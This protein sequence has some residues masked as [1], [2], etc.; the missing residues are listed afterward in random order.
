MARNFLSEMGGGESNNRE[1]VSKRGRV[2]KKRSRAYE[3]EGGGTVA[4][5]VRTN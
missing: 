3:G 4:I 1:Y 2:R 5:T